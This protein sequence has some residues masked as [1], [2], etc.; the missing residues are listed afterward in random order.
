MDTVFVIK[1]KNSI[2]T[3]RPGVWVVHSHRHGVQMSVP[4]LQMVM[5]NGVR[6]GVRG[7]NDPTLGPL[8]RW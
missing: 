2:V 3:R 6:I 8:F 1:E 5:K 7:S 4:M